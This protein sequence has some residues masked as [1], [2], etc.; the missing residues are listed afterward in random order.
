MDNSAGDPL[1]LVP[2][3]SRGVEPASQDPPHRRLR[4]YTFDPS[5]AT[6]LET[7]LIN[8]TVLQVP[9]EKLDKGPVGEYLEI[10]DYDAPSGCFYAPVELDDSNLLAQDGLAPSEGNPKFHQQMVYAVAM[11][12]IQNFELALGRKAL[13]APD[14]K[15]DP[16]TREVTDARPVHKLRVYPHAL[17]E[18][19]AYYSP[20]KKA[21]LFGYFPSVLAN[22]G[23][24]LPGGLVFTCLSH[25][26]VA[27]E[28][29]HAVLDGNLER[30]AVMGRV[31]VDEKE[32]SLCINLL[33]QPSHVA[34][35][36]GEQ[37]SLVVAHADCVWNRGCSGAL[38]GIQSVHRDA[39]GGRA[40]RA[41]HPGVGGSSPP[42]PEHDLRQRHRPP[43]RRAST[44]ARSW[45]TRNP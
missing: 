12:T 38:C 13:W 16:K 8:Q 35:V 9:W 43:S 2:S 15:R 31:T 30:N 27:H 18:A 24:N 23:E 4:V 17:R 5:L 40:L 45:R 19:N 37:A 36:L 3:H 1:D 25:D 14:F 11:S 42:Q 39:G 34:R 26:I 21:L 41:P 7:S 20:D 6:Q 29:T 33:H 28:T 32:V 10:V 44:S 22:P